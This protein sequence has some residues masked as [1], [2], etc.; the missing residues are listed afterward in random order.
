MDKSALPLSYC[1]FPRRQDSNLRPL[2]PK[3]ITHIGQPTSPTLFSD[4]GALYDNTALIVCQYL[5][6]NYALDIGWYTS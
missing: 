1:E 6:N 2:D 5:K 4:L 3:S